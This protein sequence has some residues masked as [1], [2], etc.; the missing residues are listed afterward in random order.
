[1]ISRIGLLIVLIA[2]IAVASILFA[3]PLLGLP[4]ATA[5]PTAR[6]PT[7]SPVFSPSLAASPLV[8][9]SPTAAPARTPTTTCPPVAPGGK[10]GGFHSLVDVRVG[11]QPGFD[12]VVLDFGQESGAQDDLPAFRIER[13]SSFTAI[14]GQPVPMQG[15]ALWSV[16]AEGASIADQRGGLSYKGPR[17]LDPATTLVR[18]VKL[19]EDFEAVMIWGIGLARLECP[20]VST[21]RSPLRLVIDLPELP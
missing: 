9:Q 6:I 18:D 4:P 20:R 2:S 19:V 7:P 1:M 17:D 15:N 10:A 5:S 8:V 11:H 12:R 13:A 14:S 3:R 16:R 21:L